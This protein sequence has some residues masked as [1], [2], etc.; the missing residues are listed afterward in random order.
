[1]KEIKLLQKRLLRT[2][3]GLGFM[4]LGIAFSLR[5]SASTPKVTATIPAMGDGYV[6]SELTEISVTFDQPMNTTSYSYVTLGNNFPQVTGNPQWVDAYTCVLPVNLEAGA[7]YWLSINSQ[8]NYGFHSSVGE[9]ATPFL[10]AF[11]T[12]SLEQDKGPSRE[13]KERN[14]Q[15]FTQ[16]AEI[17][18]IY[19]SYKDRLNLDWDSILKEEKA[20]LLQAPNDFIFTACT[21]NLL[22]PAQ[23]PHLL[24]QIGQQLLPTSWRTAKVNYNL[25]ASFQH[26]QSLT[27][28]SNCVVSGEVDDIGYILITSWADEAAKAI[29]A[30]QALNDKRAIIV[31]VRPN[32][33]GNELIAQAVAGCFTDKPITYAKSLV[34]D[35]ET[36]DFTKLKTRELQPN[37]EYV[38]YQGRVFVL[39][40]EQVM[41]SNEAFLLMMKKVR[42]TLIGETSYGSSGNP[43][44]YTLANGLILYVPQWLAM[45]MDGNLIE[46]K[47]IE[48]DILLDFA[49]K[50][51]VNDDPLFRESLQIVEQWSD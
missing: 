31:D 22:R 24:L 36:K 33:G 18:T 35:P 27:Q 20:N 4:M 32:S 3:L 13:Q 28:W 29:E 37:R 46:G 39:T 23:D 17:I 48:P 15:S 16:L 1:V 26:I 8:G 42:A 44:P 47:G 14:L 10:L 7:D 30:I 9:P 12:A 21:L 51:F 11:R 50:A 38:T 49:P 5:V 43:K 19:Y 2:L 34:F 45:D 41:S 25:Q 40:G 6:S